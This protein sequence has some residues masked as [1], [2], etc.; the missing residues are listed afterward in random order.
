MTADDADVVVLGAGPAGLAAAYRA[1]GNGHRVVVVER[2]ERPGGLAGSFEVAGQR[3]DFGSHRL[4]PAT[5]PDILAELQR[6]VGGALQRRR[7]NGRIRLGGRWIAFPLRAGDL[8]RHLPPSFAA[9]AVRDAVLGWTRRAHADTFADVLRAG[10]GPTICEQFYF[11][12]A[13]KIWGAPPERL[14]GEQAR[15]RVSAG[16][17]GRLVR[18]V[19]PGNRDKAHFYYPAGGFGALWEAMAA[20]SRER[21]VDI[22]YAAEATRVRLD[23]DAVEVDVRGGDSVR[24]ARLWSTLPLARLAAMADRAPDPVLLSAAAALRTRAMLLVYLVLPTDRWSPFDAHYLPALSTPVSRLSEPKNYRDG[25]DPVGRTVVCAEVPCDRGDALWE[26]PDGQLA[27]TVVESLRD[28]DLPPLEP[29]DVT[30][31]RVGAAYP[32]YEAGFE[33]AFAVLDA[34]ASAQPRLLTFGRQGL[35]AHDNSHHALA[36]GWAAADALRA[37]GE[38]DDHAWGNARARFRTHVVED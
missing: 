29:V 8:A 38:F 4:H 34:W 19:L 10:L 21:G 26:M 11:P 28:L 24:A 31:R 6:L 37:D 20:A 12:Y 17:T 2:A 9:A 33:R 32:V 25:D 22:R 18:R 7:R 1:A 36:M 30:V 27:Q 16:S 15:R 3:V 13:E 35:F 23:D 5:A 14:S